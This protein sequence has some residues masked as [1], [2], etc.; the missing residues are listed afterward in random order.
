MAWNKKLFA[1]LKKEN[2]LMTKHVH[3][4]DILYLGACIHLGVSFTDDERV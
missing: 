2:K 3:N 4:H 1:T